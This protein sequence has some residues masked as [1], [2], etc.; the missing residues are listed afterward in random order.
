MGPRSVIDYVL[1][2]RATLTDLHAGRVSRLDVCDA[3]AYLLRAARHHGES[4]GKPCPVCGAGDPGR[5]RPGDPLVHVTYGYGDELGDSSGRAWATDEL[6]ELASRF[7]DLR[8]Y[9]VEVCATCGWNHLVTSYTIG[10]GG[11]PVRRARRRA[12][13]GE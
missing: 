2:R 6:A 7:S 8:I 4:T 9:V 5:P 1:A 3:N 12:A 13:P 10:T 11:P